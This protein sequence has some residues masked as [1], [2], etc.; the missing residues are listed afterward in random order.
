MP[1]LGTSVASGLVWTSGLASHNTMVPIYSNVTQEAVQKAGLSSV[2]SAGIT[3]APVH[4][5]KYVAF[6]GCSGGLKVAEDNYGTRRFQI[7]EEEVR[8]ARE[9]AHWNCRVLGSYSQ[10]C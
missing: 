7:H 2:L 5:R 1:D 4:V 10:D 3:E 9:R 8:A 6:Y